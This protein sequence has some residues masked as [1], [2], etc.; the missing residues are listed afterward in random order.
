MFIIVDLTQGFNQIVLVVKDHKKTTFH[1][2]NKLWE[3]LVMPFGLKNAL[4]FFQRVMD[5][6]FQGA[7]FLKCYID[8]ILVHNKGLLQHWAHFEELFK[9]FHK[10]NM[11]IHPKKCEFVD[12]SVVYLRHKILP[13]G[14]MVHWAKVVAILEMPNLTDVHTLRSFI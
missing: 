10:V 6:V 5:H 9:R 3:W 1:G 8:D 14:I 4:V 7:D 12:I 11:K 2:S 13:N